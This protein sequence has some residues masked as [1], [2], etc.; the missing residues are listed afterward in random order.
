MRLR[1][2]S[3]A[4]LVVL[5]WLPALAR[6]GDGASGDEAVDWAAKAKKLGEE[7]AKAETEYYRPWREAKTD[8]E[9][10]KLGNPDPA[11]APA[12]TFLPRYLEV[13]TGAKGTAPG[14]Q[15][16]AWILGRSPR[17]PE[18][19]KAASD[20]LDLMAKDGID[21]PALGNMTMSIRYASYRLGEDRVAGALRAIADKTAVPD[22][23]GC[24]LVALAAMWNESPQAP[25][26]RK[27]EAKRMLAEV[28]EKHPKCPSAPQA[29]GILNELEHLQ[30]GMVAPD[31]DATDGAGR[32]FKLSE[33]R[34][35]VVVLDF[36]G[37]W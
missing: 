8:E 2:W 13:A 23:R 10:R 7:Y 4:A 5:A 29:K 6:A 28:I 27:A 20:A 22:N 31:F 35:R 24:A 19:E 32:K 15:A 9:R 36:W 12:A 18:G 3:A 30:V 25:A 34:G 26:E 33:Y 37:F 11:K 17:S 1:R 21:C 14:L 16:C